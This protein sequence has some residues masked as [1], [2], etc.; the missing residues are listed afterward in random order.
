MIKRS[1][2]KGIELAKF[3]IIRLLFF[4]TNV[5]QIIAYVLPCFSNFEVLAARHAGYIVSALTGFPKT[6]T[7]GLMLFVV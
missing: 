2:G 6:T 7:E 1:I 3:I 5:Y 4:G